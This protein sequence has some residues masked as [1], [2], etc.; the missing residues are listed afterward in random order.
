M[1]FIG[2][3]GTIA[4][5]GKDAFDIL[6]YG[7]N[8]NRLH[9]DDIIAALPPLRGLARVTPVRFKN[10]ESTAV[11]SGDWRDLALLCARLAEDNPELAGIVIG[12]GTATLEESAY[13]L[14]LTLKL[15][16]PVV[17]VG[18]QRPLNGISSDAPANL[19]SA[20]RVAASPDSS[21]RGV[22]IVLNDEIHAARDVSKR[23]TFRLHAFQSA[24][25]GMLGQVDGE[26]VRY[27]RRTER[28]HTLESEFSVADIAAMPRVDV[29]Y[30]YAGSDGTAI[31][32]FAAAGAKGIVL[33]GF[34]PG[35]GTPSEVEALE[36]VISRGVVALQ[37]SRAGSGG[38]LDSARHRAIGII[39]ADNLTPPKA[40]I[41]LG[42]ALAR[43]T[44][45][46]EIQRIFAM[47]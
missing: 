6:D 18:S 36:E 46:N 8:D 11:T 4:S 43:T 26:T 23:S 21:G 32:A 27:Y 37:S 40:R 12:H 41:L 16:I 10:I 7:N 9:A 29:A 45:R 30:S 35:M 22:L 17:V 20:I 2:T 24:D 1:A 25:F 15:K 38:A 19:V 14:S 5:I 13:C 31:R 44:D 39:A 47:Y 42:L 28:L 33:A 3:G 34:A